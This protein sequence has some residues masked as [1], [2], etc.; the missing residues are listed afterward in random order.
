MKV[1]KLVA[2]QVSQVSVRLGKRRYRPLDQSGEVRKP[3]QQTDL[4]R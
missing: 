4:N 2:E 3:R 1:E